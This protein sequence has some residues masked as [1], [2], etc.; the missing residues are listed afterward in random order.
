[1]SMASWFEKTSRTLLRFKNSDEFR[2]ITREPIKLEKCSGVVSINL[3]RHTT[4]HIFSGLL[5]IDFTE[6]IKERKRVWRGAL[7]PCF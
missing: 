2:L 1:M 3:P 4:L 6:R 7:R 5:S